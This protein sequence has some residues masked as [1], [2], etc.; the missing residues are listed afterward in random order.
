MDSPILDVARDE[1]QKVKKLADKAIAQLG[2]EELWVKIDP[3]ANS[4]GVLMRHMAGNMRS[5]WT[6]FLTSDGEKPDRNRD[7]EFEDFAPDRAALVA[8]WEDGWARVFA[9]LA[10]LTDA[11]LQRTVF[12]R[13]EPHSIYMAISRQVAHYAG[14][15]YQIVLLAKHLKGTGWKTLSIPKGES[16]AF[17]QRMR[18]R[19]RARG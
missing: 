2:D 15:A 4:I 11:D 14:H 10:P 5:R 13:E 19:L 8:E 6:D 12:I 3:D 1:L 9:A 16:E 18:E 7:Q 17:N